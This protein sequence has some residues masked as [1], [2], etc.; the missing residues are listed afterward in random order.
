MNFNV[1]FISKN[2]TPFGENPRSYFKDP[3]NP[4]TIIKTGNKFYIG[5][6]VKLAENMIPEMIPEVRILDANFSSP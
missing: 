3:D 6:K 5:K 4:V 1:K 2:N